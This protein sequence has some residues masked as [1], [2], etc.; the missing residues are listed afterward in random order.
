MCAYDA[1]KSIELYHTDN[2]RLRKQI[3]VLCDSLNVLNIQQ[4]NAISSSDSYE[5]L[6]I[7]NQLKQCEIEF[8]DVLNH[9]ESNIR[10]LYQSQQSCNKLT[11]TVDALSTQLDQSNAIS[12][13]LLQRNDTITTQLDTLTQQYQTL[14]QQ[15]N[16]SC[17]DNKLL[18]SQAAEYNKLIQQLKNDNELL[19]TELNENIHA[20]LLSENNRLHTLIDEQSVQIDHLLSQNE[21]LRSHQTI[22]HDRIQQLQSQLQLSIPKSIVTTTNLTDVSTTITKQ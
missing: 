7:V 18:Q 11:H 6:G 13:S 5:L 3:L 2:Q 14:H 4:C 12:D 21:Q 22:Q 19:H 17:N 20:E 1:S 9:V 16:Q 10:E 15:Y 8:S